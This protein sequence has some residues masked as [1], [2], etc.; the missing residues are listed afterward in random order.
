MDIGTL[1]ELD[2]IN[3]LRKIK[4][5]SIYVPLNDKGIDLVA[6]IGK[7]FYQIQVK[8]SKFQKHSYFWF[9]LHED[10]MVYSNN[11]LYVFVCKVP[12]RHRMMGKKWNF[13]VV[14]S[15]Q[16]RKWIGEGKMARK[17]SNPKIFNM[18]FYPDEVDSRWLY[19]NK[20]KE[21]DLTK[22]WNNFSNMD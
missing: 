7:R 20:R 19:K 11:T 2:V 8:T 21:I 6:V 5:C 12:S 4:A 18:F 10:K 15:Q 16:I 17:K 1:G 13:I 3:Y 14:P 22:Y 9:D